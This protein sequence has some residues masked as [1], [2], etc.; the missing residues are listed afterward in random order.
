MEFIKKLWWKTKQWV[1]ASTG[2]YRHSGERV[3]PDFPDQNFHDHL[4]VYRFVSQFVHQ[5][6]VLDIGCGTGYGDHYLMTQGAHSVSGI[7]KSVD[8]IGY[9]KKKYPEENLHFRVMDAQE[10]SHPD[11]SFDVVV[12]SENLE[13]LEDPEKNLSEIRRVLKEGG[14]LLLGTPNKEIASP[15]VTSSPNPFHVREFTY[16]ELRTLVRARFRSVYIFENT[17]VSPSPVGQSMKEERLQ[18][19]EV[20]IEP[21]NGR[22]VQLETLTID[23]THLKNTHSFMVVAW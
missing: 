20:G 1:F 22:S 7:D 10:L 18:R 23:L 4:E 19:G 16:E 15:G 11:N 9:A 13:H 6:S 12:S 3:C 5:K 14:L 21:G 8:A 2:S 17:A